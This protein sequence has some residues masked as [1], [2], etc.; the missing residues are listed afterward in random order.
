MATTKIVDLIQRAEIITQDK[1]SVRWPKYEWLKWYNDAI[2]F[3]V[4]RRPDVSVKNV[5][6]TVDN[7]DTKQSLP[8]D[9]LSL[10]TVVRNVTSGR[11]IREIPR[12][13]LDDQYTDWHMHTSDDIDHFAYD[14]RDPKSFYVYPR[15][16]GASHTIEIMYPYA[17]EAVTITDFDT[18]T[19][20]IGI[21][22]SYVNPVL[23]FMLYRAYSKDADY[24]ENA[25]RAINHLQAAESSIGT[26]TQSDNAMMAS[27]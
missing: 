27:E 26:K 4:N 2:L 19:Q 7:T 24:A 5:N 8:A 14:P 15:P 13:V 21:D 22:D 18:D 20:T 23:D 6:F 25:Q 10:F 12:E 11:P 1:T 9:G 17:P 3:V 16:T